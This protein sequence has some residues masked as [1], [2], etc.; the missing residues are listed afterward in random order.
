MENK[1][2]KAYL[3]Y[4][5]LGLQ[6]L[7]ALAIGIWGGLSLDQYANTLP[8]FTLLGALLGLTTAMLILA[9]AIKTN[10]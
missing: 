3:K 8:W 5:T 10:K 6:Q 2:F 4:T 1:P 7:G 9:R